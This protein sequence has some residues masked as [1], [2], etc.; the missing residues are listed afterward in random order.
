MAVGTT[1]LTIE[2]SQAVLRGRGQS[3]RI[4]LRLDDALAGPLEGVAF[5]AEVVASVNRITLAAASGSRMATVDQANR[6]GE[7]ALRFRDECRRLAAAI[8]GQDA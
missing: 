3:Q 4:V 7:R 5:A 1:P 2:A 6:L 8:E